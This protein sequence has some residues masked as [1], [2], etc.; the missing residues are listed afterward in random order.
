[1][2]PA[3]LALM[4]GVAPTDYHWEPIA[5]GAEH[6]V[7]RLEQTP[8]VADGRLH[9]VRIDPTK[10]EFIARAARE[11]NTPLSNG[12]AWAKTAGLAVVVNAGMFESDNMTHTGYFRVGEQENNPS[13]RKDYKAVL[14]IG[15]RRQGLP[16]ATVVDVDTQPGFPFS[17]YD[18]VIQNLRL[19]KGPG[20]NVWKPSKKRWSEA[21]VGTDGRGRLLF[22]FYRSPLSM[23]EF[24]RKLLALGLGI[25]HLMHME[26]GPEAT[27]SIHG[28]GIDLDL[29]GSYE[30]GFNPDDS[31]EQQWGIPNIIG[32][33]RK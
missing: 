17:D 15:P 10:A 7:I 13:W 18:V 14:V 27:L 29:A 25:T 22:F 20:R 31:N 12:A 24:N 32:V 30:T 4:L 1:M 3:I 21:A 16:A 9:V 8:A 11:A 6:T 26:G 33:K 28:G 23:F 5:L 2:S 19:I